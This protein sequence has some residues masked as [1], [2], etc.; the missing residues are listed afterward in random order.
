[1]DGIAEG[2]FGGVLQIAMLRQIKIFG[3]RFGSIEI[4]EVLLE[5]TGKVNIIHAFVQRESDRKK[6][7]KNALNYI[8]SMPIAIHL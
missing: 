4:M 6:K 8:K 3:G 7:E 2:V 5:N 1:M